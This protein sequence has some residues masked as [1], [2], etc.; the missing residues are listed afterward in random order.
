V[1]ITGGAGFIGSHLSDAYLQSGDE[2]FVIDDL[3][4]GS[5]E[6]IR[7]LKDHPRFHYTIESV[8]NQPVTAELVDQCD[9]VFHM[10]AAV[11]VKIIVESQVS[12]IETKESGTEIILYIANIT[13]MKVL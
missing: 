10:A 2:V 7:H 8:H 1:L 11:G 5:I 12:T 4:T 13:N 9:A 6:N 3:S